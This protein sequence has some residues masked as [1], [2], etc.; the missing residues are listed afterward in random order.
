MDEHA[1]IWELPEL[2]PIRGFGWCWWFWLV[3]LDNPRAPERPRQLMVL[4]SRKDADTYIHDTL[5][6]TGPV[7]RTER[8]DSFDGVVAGWYYDGERMDHGLALEPGRATVERGGAGPSSGRVSIEV[9][10]GGEYAFSGDAGAWRLRVRNERRD[11]DLGIHLD[12]PTAFTRPLAGGKRFLGGRFMY[13]VVKL[14]RCRVDGSVDGEKVTGSAYFQRIGLNN[15]ALPWFWGVVHLADGSVLKYFFPHLSTA[16]LRH[17]P[18]DRMPAHERLWLPVK[19][20]ME[21]YHAPT[22]TIHA[23]S[24]GTVARRERPGL[25]PAWELSFGSRG[26]RLSATLESYDRT[27]WRFRARRPSI[28]INDLYYNEYPCRVA[29]LRLEGAGGTVTLGDTGPGVG[30]VEHTWGGLF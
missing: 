26:E 21:F 6:R 22:G 10:S 15:P 12:S 13:S 29:A 30:N 28:P 16:V 23:F 8:A 25:P 17:D 20:E 18:K 7:A 3:F 2:E 1:R 4:W 24:R 11:M 27:H 19:R 14:N 9:P 5:Y